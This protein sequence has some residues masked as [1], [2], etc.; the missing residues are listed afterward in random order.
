MEPQSKPSF[1][2]VHFFLLNRRCRN[3]FR[4]D[5]AI[6]TDGTL[7]HTAHRKRLKCPF[8]TNADILSK[9][10]LSQAKP[11]SYAQLYCFELVKGQAPKF[12][13]QLDS[14]VSTDALRV[15]HAIF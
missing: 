13:N 12:S 6:C 1:E 8:G 11:K 14:R 9:V 4:A 3:A 5:Y 15:K 7:L 2:K 10:G